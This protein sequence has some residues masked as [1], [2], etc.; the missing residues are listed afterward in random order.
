MRMRVRFAMPRQALWDAAKLKRLLL[1]KEPLSAIASSATTD[2]TEKCHDYSTDPFT[3]LGKMLQP[4][5]KLNEAGSRFSGCIHSLLDESRNGS[6]TKE[7]SEG[8]A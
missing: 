5:L 3:E 1:E 4:S 2:E 8:T 7:T 6:D